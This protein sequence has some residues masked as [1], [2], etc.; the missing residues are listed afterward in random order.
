MKPWLASAG[1][2]AAGFTAADAGSFT[3]IVRACVQNGP[4]D[5]EN[6]AHDENI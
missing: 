3:S 1:A 2:V 4:A 6:F 5:L